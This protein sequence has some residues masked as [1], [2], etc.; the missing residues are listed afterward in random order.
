MTLAAVP[1]PLA[2]DGDEAVLTRAAMLE[3]G[4]QIHHSETQYVYY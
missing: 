2:L 1:L 3:L 4:P